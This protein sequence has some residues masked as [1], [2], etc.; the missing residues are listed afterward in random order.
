MTQARLAYNGWIFCDPASSVS[1]AGALNDIESG[2]IPGG[3]TV[4]CTLT[5]HGLKDP[6][7]AMRQSTAPVQKVPAELDAVKRVILG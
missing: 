2:K 3:S 5:G 6:D 4:V 1:V 7:I